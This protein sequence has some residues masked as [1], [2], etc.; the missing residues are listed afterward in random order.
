MISAELLALG[1]VEGPLFKGCDDNRH[2]YV[3]SFE[4]TDF[5]GSGKDRRFYTESIDL[6]IV[7][8]DDVEAESLCLRFGSE[9]PDYYSGPLAIC[10]SINSKP[11]TTAFHLLNQLGR[12]T[13]IPKTAS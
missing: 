9:P 13:W 11:Y 4:Y 7:R 8:H 2:H 3:C 10:M 5:T 6:Y 12:F 1:V